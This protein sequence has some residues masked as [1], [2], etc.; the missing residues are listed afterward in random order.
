MYLP[1]IQFLFPLLKLLL[2]IAE[3]HKLIQRL[4]INVAVLLQVIIGL[5]QLFE[6]L[7]QN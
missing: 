7:E 4:L 3:A 2:L 1:P 5:L 6:Q